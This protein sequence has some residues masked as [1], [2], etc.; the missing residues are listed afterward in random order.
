MIPGRLSGGTS[1]VRLRKLPVPTWL[2][3]EVDLTVAVRF[4]GH[5]FPVRRDLRTRFG[6]F[7]IGEPGELRSRPAESPERSAAAGPPTR[8]TP[9]TS[10]AS[11][12]TH[13]SHVCHVLRA[14]GAVVTSSAGNHFVDRVDLDPD[15]TDVSQALLRIL[16][17][18]SGTAA[19]MRAGVAGGKRRPV[20]VALE[21]FRDGV[22]GGLT[23]KRERARSTSR[24][25]HSRMPRYQ[26]AC[27]R[28]D[29]GPARDSY[30]RRC[31]RSHRPAIDSD[32]NPGCRELPPSPTRS[33]APSRRHLA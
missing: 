16:W 5:E 6:A 14:A 29:R 23:R 28:C 31:R 21:N 9:A 2:D 20:R 12:P 17:P 24:R 3:P 26:R 7:P 11:D 4:E 27:R 10:A 13:G 25:G 19:R 32:R 33:R 15:V 22:R 30:T 8:P 18:G 1:W